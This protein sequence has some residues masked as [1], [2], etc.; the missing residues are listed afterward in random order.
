LS[1]DI[2]N[3]L[4]D[5]H[6]WLVLIVD[7]NL[8][9]AGKIKYY[10]NQPLLGRGIKIYMLIYSWNVNGLRAVVKKGFGDFLKK[11]SPDI[12]CLQETKIS[13]VAREKVEFDFPDYE[14]YLNAADRPGYSGTATLI[15]SG[16]AKNIKTK[17]KLPW[18]DEG[19]V[20]IFELLFSKR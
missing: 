5:T 14:E 8:L 11:E 15:K 19:R 4:S 17:N 13:H 1:P 10:S 20:Q 7:K 3:N 2:I 18:D 12:L 9:L 6:P 16:L